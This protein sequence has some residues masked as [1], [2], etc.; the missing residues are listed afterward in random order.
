[1]EERMSS[2][3]EELAEGS[4]TAAALMESEAKF[5]QMMSEGEQLQAKV[6]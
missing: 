3:T 4:D 1:M 2:L 6:A 5:Q